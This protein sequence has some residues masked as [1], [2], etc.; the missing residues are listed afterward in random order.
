MMSP[1][2]EAIISKL[3]QRRAELINQIKKKIFLKLKDNHRTGVVEVS[4]E[5]SRYRILRDNFLRATT[6]L[7]RMA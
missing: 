1:K 5:S 2:Q 7:D 4:H 3:E 6:N